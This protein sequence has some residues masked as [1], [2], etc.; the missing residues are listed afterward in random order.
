MRIA[1]LAAAGLSALLIG[2][3][4]VSP[5]VASLYDVQ[6][7]WTKFGI[8][9]IKAD[10][11]SS[12]GYGMGY[13]YANDNMCV[14]MEDIVATRGN[15]AKHFGRD[16]R[17]EIYSNG[18]S[19]T[20]VDSDFFWRHVAIPSIIQDLRDKQPTDIDDA[21]TGYA[22]GFSRYVREIASGAHLGR[23][24]SCRDSTWLREISTDDMYYRIYRLAIVASSSVFMTEIANTQPP[25]VGI[26]PIGVGKPTAISNKAEPL[27][28]TPDQLSEGFKYFTESENRFGSNMY[29]FGEEMTE[30]GKPL[31]FGNPHFPW[32]GPER[33]WAMHLQKSAGEDGKEADIMGVSLHGAPAVLIGFN[34]QVAWSH[35]VSSAYRFTFYELTLGSKNTSYVFDAGEVAMEENEITVEI[36]EADGSIVEETRTLY[37]SHYGPMVDISPGLIEWGT[38]PGKAY[39]LRDA[40]A[41]NDRLFSQFFVWNQAQSIEEFKEQQSS[42]LGVPWVNTAAIGK[43]RDGGYGAVHYSDVTVVP[44]V[45]DEKSAICGGSVNQAVG[46]LVP[47]LPVLDGSKSI[48][49]WDQDADTEVDGIFGPGNLPTLDRQDYVHNC[50]DSYWLTNWR[51]PVTGYDA[52]IGPENTARSLRTR[53]CIQQAEELISADTKL[54]MKLLQDIVLGSRVYTADTER[55]TP[56]GALCSSSSYTLQEGD[57][58]G[59]V[60]D[61]SEACT[62]LANWDGRNNL[63]SVGGHI[64]REF[65]RQIG[66]AAAPFNT[67]FNGRGDQ[68][69]QTPRDLDTSA[70]SVQDGFAL[71]VKKLN[72]NNVSLTSTTA[73]NQWSADNDGT[74]RIP[75][76]GGSGTAGSFTIWRGTHGSPTETEGYGQTTYGNSYIQT[77]T[78]DENDDVQAEAFLTYSQSTDPGSPH[79]ADFTRAYSRKE[80]HP[81]PYTEAEI[82]KEV[83]GQV[84]LRE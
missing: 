73:E 34:N 51:E 56:L 31:L 53:L 80:W 62:L 6:V 8:P 18:R 27:E 11:F 44:N 35:T 17:F 49:D 15:R 43:S 40:N 66:G 79:Y 52:I 20:N 16:G 32:R 82:S 57:D 39:T 48:C 7:R 5:S 28:L 67:A 22:A 75:V 30:S 54:N 69:Y 38:P 55:T 26:P 83:I 3:G 81:M 72:D 63:E 70:A 13:A 61:I 58:A 59:T 33:L 84:R 21:I 37:R 9:H 10:D 41:E 68:A 46:Q 36:K 12:I 19:A 76:F 71:A 47:G 42:V 1:Q 23:H 25:A 45:S 74:T 14:L 77:V 24:A 65:W 50:N 60:V 64:W 2:C 29:A 4:G 78:F